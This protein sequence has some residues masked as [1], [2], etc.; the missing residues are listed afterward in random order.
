MS[1]PAPQTLAVLAIVTTVLMWAS[2]FVIIRA[3]A[4]ELS[5]APWPCCGCWPDL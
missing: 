3:Y 4:L 2:S 5:P 1:R